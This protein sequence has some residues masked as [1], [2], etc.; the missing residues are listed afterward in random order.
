MSR[1]P[2][3]IKED[4]SGA[5]TYVMVT[6]PLIAKEIVNLIRRLKNKSTDQNADRS[7]ML[8]GR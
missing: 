7:R 4:E 3:S 5:L 8:K 1:R 6:P 2:P